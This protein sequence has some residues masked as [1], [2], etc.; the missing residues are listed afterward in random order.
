MYSK[1][2][3]TIT[4]KA[5]LTESVLRMFSLQI[6]PEVTQNMFLEFAG[7]GTGSNVYIYIYMCVCA[8]VLFCVIRKS[9]HYILL[10]R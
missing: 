5:T 8:C 7:K 2:A 4:N 6:V 3:Y 9:C 1:I 10:F